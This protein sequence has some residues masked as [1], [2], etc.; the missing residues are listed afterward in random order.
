MEGEEQTRKDP[1]RRK[2][3]REGGGK[4]GREGRG[5]TDRP[6]G[7]CET[8]FAN[9][10]IEVLMERDVMVPSDHHLERAREGDGGGDEDKPHSHII[11]AVGCDK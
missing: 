6:G 10:L 5:R 2:G 3:G 4:G 7:S 1:V 8:F 9:L 11:S